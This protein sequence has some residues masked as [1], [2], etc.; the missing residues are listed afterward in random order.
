MRS[1]VF[2]SVSNTP[3]KLRESRVT[4]QASFLESLP[5]LTH[6]KSTATTLAP[7]I[8][9]M[10]IRRNF[11]EPRRE[12]TSSPS[13]LKPQIE[14]VQTCRTLPVEQNSLA[15]GWSLGTRR[16]NLSPSQRKTF[17]GEQIN[18]IMIFRRRL[19]QSSPTRLNQEYSK[20][21]GSFFLKIDRS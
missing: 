5:S 2:S 20:L 4:K 15:R 17:K 7:S 12:R 3:S 1:R 21:I 16:G 11:S 19:K 14:T 13:L 10:S 18:Q 6:T 8:E 9:R